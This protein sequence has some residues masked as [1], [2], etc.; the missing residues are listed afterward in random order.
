LGYTFSTPQLA[1]RNSPV[2]PKGAVMHKNASAMLTTIDVLIN[3]LIFL[4]LFMF[5][6][7]LSIF[8][9]FVLRYCV[10]HANK[11]IEQYQADN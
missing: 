6:L 4:L 7:G 8:G 3:V 11:I 9:P 1:H 10:D 2:Y 5:C